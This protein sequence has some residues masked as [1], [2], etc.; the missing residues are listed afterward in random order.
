[1]HKM[2]YEKAIFIY[3]TKISKKCEINGDSVEKMCYYIF[4]N[5]RQRENNMINDN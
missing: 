3:E 1:M 4:G 5:K 2:F